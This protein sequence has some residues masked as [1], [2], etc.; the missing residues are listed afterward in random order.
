MPDPYEE[1][2]KAS[3]RDKRLTEMDRCSV[4]ITFAKLRTVALSTVL[5]LSCE[6]LAILLTI[7]KFYL[8]A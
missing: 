1:N 3:L 8:F 5:K 4:P 6:R 2:L 7:L